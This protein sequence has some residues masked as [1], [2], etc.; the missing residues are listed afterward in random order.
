[1]KLEPGQNIFELGSGSGWNTA[2]MADI[3]GDKGK[4][5]SVEVIPEL[6]ERARKI[7]KE[8]AVLN[9]FVFQ[10]DGFEGYPSEAPHDRVIFTA[11][12]KE[13]PQNLF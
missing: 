3:I 6:A 13:F 1:M 11:G 10:G 7:L 2:M 9:A 8:Q 12:S 4:V 5:I